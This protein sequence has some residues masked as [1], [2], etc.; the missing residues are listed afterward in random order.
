MKTPKVTSG[1]LLFVQGNHCRIDDKP[2][3]FIM[4]IYFQLLNGCISDI[5]STIAAGVVRCIIAGGTICRSIAAG[6]ICGSI[7]GI[8][9]R[10]LCLLRIIG[11]S[12]CSPGSII[13]YSRDRGE[14][15]S[16]L[17]GGVAFI[18]QGTG[19][20]LKIIRQ[21]L[22]SIFRSDSSANNEYP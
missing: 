17:V 11:R 8:F 15:G 19:I 6:V 2:A 5:P 18:V 12:L 3:F 21:K 13:I 20:I 14:S 9:C 1:F 10:W 7:A 22:W 16:S 4:K